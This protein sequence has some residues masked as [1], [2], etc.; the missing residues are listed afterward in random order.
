MPLW[1]NDILH[2]NSVF[3]GATEIADE[4][5]QELP[6]FCNLQAANLAGSYRDR[7]AVRLGTEL[8]SQCHPGRLQVRI[9]AHFE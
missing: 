2:I 6:F 8:I 7:S 9:R 5:V 1:S 4:I 3:E